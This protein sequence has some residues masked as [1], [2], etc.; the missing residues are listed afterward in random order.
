MERQIPLDLSSEIPKPLLDLITRERQLGDAYIVGG[1]IRDALIGTGSKDIDVE[2]FGMHLDALINVLKP[3]GRVD[4]VGKS[5]GVV[6]LKMKGSATFDFSI[7]R[8]ERK[9]AKGHRGFQMES[10]LQMS[11]KEASRRRD[12]TINA[13]FYD[14]RKKRIIDCH[15]GIADLDAKRLCPVDPKSFGQDPL[16]VLRAMQFL[17]RFDF[18]PDPKLITMSRKIADTFKELPKERIGEEWIKWCTKSRKPSLGLKFLEDC[19]W[20]RHF[21]ELRKMRGTPQDSEWHPEGDVFEHTMHCCDA[22]VQLDDWK[23]TGS[24][25]RSVF[26]L[27]VLLHDTGKVFTT[28]RQ[29][30]SGRERILSPGHEIRSAR[31]APRF[32]RR[33][34]IP[35]AVQDWVIP[36]I[37]N[38][39]IYLQEQPSD[40][41]VRRLAHRLKPATIRSLGIVMKADAHGR[42]PLPKRVPKNLLSLLDHAQKLSLAERIPEPILRGR[43]LI[44][45]GYEA[46][47]TMGRILK[48]AFE[49]QLEGA[50]HDRETGLLWMKHRNKTNPH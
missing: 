49:A 19:R 22:L 40:R 20:I 39:M 34:N 3:F 11:R 30:Q 12:F 15:N 46:G 8:F 1:F 37:A 42:P 10:N 41:A 24:F 32:M 5:F 4:L 17:S 2:V 23:N 13:M 26:M 7:P 33:L 36:L 43:D 28:K 6:K 14:P 9:I 47:P 44:A 48:E 25:E 50:F 21:P 18:S 35:R 29:I 16:R 38:H 45:S 31:I 27:A